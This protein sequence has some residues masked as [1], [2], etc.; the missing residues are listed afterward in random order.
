MF[1]VDIFTPKQFGAFIPWLVIHRGSLSVLAH[2][3]TGDDER[4]HTQVSLSENVR[5]R[6]ERPDI[7]KLATWVGEKLDLD[8]SV[9]RKMRE[10]HAK[11]EKLKATQ[12]L[13]EGEL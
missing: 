11:L 1:K 6:H 2:P 8:L 13:E 12:D 10:V 5:R 9:F 3:N 7:E 4:D